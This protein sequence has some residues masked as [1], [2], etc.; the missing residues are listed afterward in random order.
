MEGLTKNET[1]GRKSTLKKEKEEWKGVL[2][3]RK[4]RKST[5]KKKREE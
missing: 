4:G 2:E 3:E 1:K 5:L